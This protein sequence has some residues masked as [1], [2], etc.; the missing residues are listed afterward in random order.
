MIVFWGNK[1][2]EIFA[3]ELGV[4]NVAMY[5]ESSDEALY[6]KPKQSI[7]KTIAITLDNKMKPI[8]EILGLILL[9]NSQNLVL[10]FKH[11][12]DQEILTGILTSN[13]I[14]IEMAD[15]DGR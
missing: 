8:R 15:K 9:Y 10:D 4:Y 2:P 7:E 13:T 5:V 11:R 14:T 3:E 6:I 12:S 1:K